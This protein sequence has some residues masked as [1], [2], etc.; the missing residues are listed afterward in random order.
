MTIK[1]T[2]SDDR[3][4][5]TLTGTIFPDTGVYEDDDS[6]MLYEALEEAAGHNSSL[7]DAIKVGVRRVLDQ[8]LEET[9][10]FAD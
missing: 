7:P 2:L 5:F 10:P 3:K 4:S 6:Q 8:F 1:V 9:A